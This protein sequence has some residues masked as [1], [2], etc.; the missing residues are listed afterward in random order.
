MFSRFV[1]CQRFNPFDDGDL[2]Q[3]SLRNAPTMSM[4]VTGYAEVLR[5]KLYGGDL[6]IATL[7]WLF[8]SNGGLWSIL[9]TKDGPDIV[10]GILTKLGVDGFRTASNDGLWSILNHCSNF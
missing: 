8:A 9:R 1:S 5:T 7:A 6:E 2:E 10:R 3:M 4:N